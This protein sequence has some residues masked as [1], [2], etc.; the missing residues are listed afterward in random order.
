MT[1]AKMP[2]ALLADKR[3]IL[4]PLLN[5]ELARRARDG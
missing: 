2:V 1:A 4:V 5:Q 3:N